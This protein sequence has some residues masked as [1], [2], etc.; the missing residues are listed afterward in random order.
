V[1]AQS[2]KRVV[3]HRLFLWDNYPVNDGSPTMHL[4]PLSGREPDLCEVIDGYISN[5]MCSQNQINRI[6]LATVA[7]YTSDPHA[8][9][10]AR[11]IGQAILRLAPSG[12]E[13]AVLKE[14][15]EAYPGFIVAGGGTGTNPVRLKFGD[16]LAEDVTRLAAAKFAEQMEH[17]ATRLGK[18]FPKQFLDAKHAVLADIAWMKEQL[19]QIKAWNTRR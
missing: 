1:A 14:L 3:K 5:P 18:H 9:K 12:P 10:P 2:F 17:L 13:Q 11:A 16:L 7:D 8:Y 19:A 6:P 15:V 4:G